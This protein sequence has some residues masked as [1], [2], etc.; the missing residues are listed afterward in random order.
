M[1]TYLGC[2]TRGSVYQVPKLKLQVTASVVRSSVRYPMHG[3]SS[4]LFRLEAVA[5]LSP[6][7]RRILEPLGKP[8]RRAWQQLDEVKV[9]GGRAVVAAPRRFVGY[10]PSSASPL[11]PLPPLPLPVSSAQL[12]SPWR[13]PRACGLGRLLWPE[14]R[15]WAVRETRNKALLQVQE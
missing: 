11:S 6:P 12:I 15:P 10:S 14:T 7:P 2:D 5:V 8:A 1:K 3:G 13:T 4:E 9:S